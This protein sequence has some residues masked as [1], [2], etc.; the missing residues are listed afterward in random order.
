[1]WEIHQKNIKTEEAVDMADW[2][3][4]LYEAN[5]YHKYT[6]MKYFIDQQDVDYH[7]YYAF[8]DHIYRGQMKVDPSTLE[9][10]KH[11]YGHMIYCD[12]QSDTNY[13]SMSETDYYIGYFED[14]K[15]S[16]FGM[17]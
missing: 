9:A 13:N 12:P 5:L 17:L 6:M 7:D 2:K 4:H 15:F 10:V 8:D 1:M 14:N 16:G 11:G 3:D